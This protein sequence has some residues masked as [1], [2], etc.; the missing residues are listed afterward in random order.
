MN[1]GAGLHLPVH[2]SFWIFNAGDV[3]WSIIGGMLWNIEPVR[4]ESSVPSQL[5]TSSVV[6]YH[7]AAHT[8]RT[9][10]LLL[11]SARLNFSILTPR[12]VLIYY[13]WIHGGGKNQ[14]DPAQLGNEKA[15]VKDWLV[16]GAGNMSKDKN[17]GYVGYGGCST[18]CI[19]MSDSDSSRRREPHPHPHPEKHINLSSYY[20]VINGTAELYCHAV[21]LT[22]LPGA[23]LNSMPNRSHLIELS[24]KY[25][26]QVK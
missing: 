7:H 20:P 6:Y 10:N 2:P 19:Y 25:T 21:L 23:Y 15:L 1:E 17:G 22:I 26:V 11:F 14:M 4:C 16:I 3:V 24:R 5:S 13:Y 9:H 8:I 12:F 18:Y